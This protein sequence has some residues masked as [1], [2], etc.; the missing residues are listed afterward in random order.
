M[1]AT[2]KQ[3]V[4]DIVWSSPQQHRVFCTHADRSQE[5][6]LGLLASWIISLVRLC[7]DAISIA[8]QLCAL[9]RRLFG[10]MRMTAVH[11]LASFDGSLDER[12]VSDVRSSPV[13]FS[14]DKA[15]VLDVDFR[16]SS[17]FNGSELVLRRCGSDALGDGVGVP[18][19]DT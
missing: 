9:R 4:L 3:V 18:D 15:R 2:W 14:G 13:F 8:Q 5:F 12:G 11:G 19:V 17:G 7:S 1:T 10:L 6:P 16:R